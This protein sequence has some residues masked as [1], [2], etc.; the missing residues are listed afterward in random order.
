MMVVGLA[1]P[2]GVGKSTIAATCFRKHMFLD[3]ALADEI[4]VRAVATG[5]ASYEDVYSSKKP[6]AVRKWLQE[7]GTERGRHLYGDDVWVRALFARLRRM[8]EEWQ[9]D[10]FVISDV[11]FASEI[12]YIR[13]HGGLVFRVDAPARQAANGLTAEQRA[14]PSEQGL[15]SLTES[16]FDGVILNDPEHEYAVQPRVNSLLRQYLPGH[17]W[18]AGR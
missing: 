2:A 3:V 12:R 5:V 8:N 9:L 15:V 1:G 14:H 16:D 17:W 7:E 10:R 13:S 4:K 6:E 11:R 18:D